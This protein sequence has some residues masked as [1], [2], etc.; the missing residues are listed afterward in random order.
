MTTSLN[1]RKSLASWS[2]VTTGEEE[3]GTFGMSVLRRHRL[4]NTDIE[5]RRSTLRA[6]VVDIRTPT[7]ATPGKNP[8][9]APQEESSSVE[10]SYRKV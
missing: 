2:A 6:A 9:S 4:T 5:R 7:R 1:S 8:L 3:F 10:A